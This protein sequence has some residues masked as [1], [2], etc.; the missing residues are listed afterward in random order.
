MET[1]D[2]ES[3][4][5]GHTETTVDSR[6]VSPSVRVTLQTPD[7]LEA[8]MA[9]VRNML[10][11]LVLVLAAI[12]SLSFAVT[13]CEDTQ[14]MTPCD[15]NCRFNCTDEMRICEQ[16]CVPGCR[17]PRRTPVLHEGKCIKKTE[18]PEQKNCPFGKVWNPMGK[19]CTPTCKNPKPECSSRPEDRQ[20]RCECPTERPFWYFNMNQCVAKGECPVTKCG[21]QP[22]DAAEQ[23]CCGSTINVKPNRP[24]CCGEIAYDRTT[25]L[26][27][28]GLVRKRKSQSSGCCGTESFTYTTHGCCRGHGPPTVYSR[29]DQICCRGVIQDRP[30]GGY[31]CGN[32][33]YSRYK[34]IC[35]MGQTYD[36][37][38]KICCANHV[39]DRV[40]YH[41]CCSDVLYDHRKLICCNA[42]LYPRV[43]RRRCCASKDLYDAKE[44]I[45]CWGVMFTRVP[46]IWCC[47]RKSFD[48]RN[49]HDY[50]MPF[51]KNGI[52]LQVFVCQKP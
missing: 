6:K 19:P 18:C 2:E 3:S 36:R 49:D 46:G 31:C 30:I 38:K 32:V 25:H 21:D 13:K 35:C 41:W 4:S 51:T 23:M 48:K 17:C 15:G 43:P 42:I 1:T 24:E 12:V 45:C 8:I 52:P 10:C 44:K 9:K 50:I 27:C 37:S 29:K 7:T 28:G 47:G 33:A 40:P 11:I 5:T 16:A 20:P 22:Y 14:Y 34:K 39:Y 26:C